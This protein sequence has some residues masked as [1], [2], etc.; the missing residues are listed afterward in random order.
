MSPSPSDARA[1]AQPDP[2]L[3]TGRRVRRVG[4]SW[5]LGRERRHLP[6]ALQ[7]LDENLYARLATAKVPV[8]DAVLPRLSRAA[9]HSKLWIAIAVVFAAV[10]RAKGRRAASRGLRAVALTSAIVNGPIKLVAN[11]HRPTGELIPAARRLARVPTSSS[12]PSGHTASA[13]AFATAVGIEVPRA[14]AP[15]GAL[16]AA[17][18]VSRVYTGVHYPLDVAA[19]AALG[20]TAAILTRTAAEHATPEPVGE[21]IAAARTIEVGRGAGLTILVNPSAGPALTRPPTDTLREAFPDAKILDDE[22]DPVAAADAAVRAGATVLAV[23]GGDGSINGIAGV[24]HAHGVPLGVIPT[25]TL[26]HLARDLA[27]DD[28]AAAIET[29]RGGRLARIDVATIAERPFLNTASFA[30]YADI[31]DARERL[32]R[33]IGKWPAAVVAL[34]RVAHG[35]P[36]RVEIDGRAMRI[37]AIFVGNGRYAPGLVP[38]ARLSLDDGRLDV[39]ILR[40]DRRAPRLRALLVAGPERLRRSSAFEAWTCRTLEVRSLE[41]PLRLAHD[42]ET[43]DGPERFMITKETDP[44]EVFVP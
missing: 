25:G 41:G 21:R 9:N 33:R 30:A 11:R 20:A 8:L 26:N 12:F 31:V 29:I 3:D 17:V 7:R 28:V 40:A 14:A 2:A 19:G 35:P 36:T 18:G 4:S 1:E 22:E 34:W 10:G 39:R 32:E 24:A 37:W 42:G 38:N 5:I 13:V 15:L 43:F 6:P 16:A 23:A 44:L 27:I